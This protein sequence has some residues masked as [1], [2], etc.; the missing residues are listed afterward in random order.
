MVSLPLLGVFFVSPFPSVAAG[1][2]CLRFGFV[3]SSLLFSLDDIICS[4]RFYISFIC[5]EFPNLYFT[6]SSYFTCQNLNL[7]SSQNWRGTDLPL[8]PRFPSQI[9]TSNCLTWEPRS[10]FRHLCFPHPAPSHPSL[11]PFHHLQNVSCAF[12]FVSIESISPFSLSYCSDLSFGPHT[13]LA[14][15]PFSLRSSQRAFKRR[16][17]TVT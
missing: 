9:T 3:P 1:L 6:R 12:P 7:L 2:S 11:S 14:F 10:H 17:R 4:L 16:G 5:W 8:T 15:L 13:S